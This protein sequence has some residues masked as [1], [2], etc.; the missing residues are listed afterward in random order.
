MLGLIDG[1]IMFYRLYNMN[2]VMQRIDTFWLI[3]CIN[4]QVCYLN[5]NYIGINFEK[6]EFF[7]P[8]LYA[9]FLDYFHPDIKPCFIMGSKLS[10]KEQIQNPIDKTF[11]NCKLITTVSVYNGVLSTIMIITFLFSSYVSETDLKRRMKIPIVFLSSQQLREIATKAMI[12]ARATLASTAD[13]I[14]I[15]KPDHNLW[16]KGNV[17]D[18]PI[19]MQKYLGYR[20]VM[21]KGGDQ[22]CMEK[23]LQK[24]IISGMQDPKLDTFRNLLPAGAPVLDFLSVYMEKSEDWKY[25]PR[26]TIS[27]FQNE[28]GLSY[29]MLN[30]VKV[31]EILIGSTPEKEVDEILL[32]FWAEYFKDQKILPTQVVS[33]DVE[34]IQA[35]LYDVYR[36][37]GRIPCSGEERFAMEWEDQREFEPEDRWTQ[38]PV[39]IMIG[40]G[41]NH[42]L[43]LSLDLNQDS[44]GYY[45][46]NRIKV[47]D[48][49]IK[50]LTMLPVCTGV[51]I[52]HDVRDIEYFFSLVSGVDINMKGFIDLSSLAVLTGYKMQTRNMP[53]MAM[54]VLGMTMNK[55]C[56]TADETWG[57]KWEDVPKALKVYALGDL[58]MG[59]MTYLVLAAVALRDFMPDPDIVCSYF[60]T[61]EQYQV[62]KWFMKLLCASL[63]SAEI[64][65]EDIKIASSRQDL[66]RTLRF[67]YSEDSG[68]REEPTRRIG[69]W[70]KMI[71]GWPSI[72]RGGC[73]YLLQARTQ[74]LDVARVWRQERIVGLSGE[75]NLVPEVS[76]EIK[77]FSVFGIQPQ[78]LDTVDY[79]QPTTDSSGLLRP[80]SLKSKLLMINPEDVKSYVIGKFCAKQPRLQRFIVLE[81][82]R[83][84]LN[85]ITPFLRRM[86]DDVN[87]QKF[88]RHLYDPLRHLFR[89]MLDQEA[90]KVVFMDGLLRDSLRNKREEEFKVY[91]RLL[92][93]GEIRQS[94]IKFL[95]RMIDADDDK[96]RS[97]WVEQ[98]PQLPHWVIQKQRRQARGQKRERSASEDTSEKKKPRKETLQ[99]IDDTEPLREDGHNL[100]ESDTEVVIV[101]EEEIDP[102]EGSSTTYPQVSQDE[103]SSESRLM[104]LF[105]VTN[106]VTK[107][108]APVALELPV[109]VQDE[110]VSPGRLTAQDEI[111]A[112]KPHSRRVI[113]EKR[114]RSKGKKKSSKRF[115]TYDE[116]I[117]AP[118]EM[119]SDNEF[120]L[121]MEFSEFMDP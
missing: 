43:M 80:S 111:S 77:S 84:N 99:S 13:G 70:A 59:H 69:M 52:K 88:Y 42:A 10:L 91:Q 81:W 54:Q 44:K 5:Y 7:Q 93:E 108:L 94:R 107:Q 3:K 38:I 67:R 36:I 51:G 90:L 75:G 79:N 87:F 72:T 71:G 24:V 114:K 31:K 95:D 115:M 97:R 50:F 9:R 39:K 45:L 58:K 89:R 100:S 105:D 29:E 57:R 110:F 101:S 62:I 56:S 86:A 15:P 85:Q 121:E 17:Y 98:I 19:L 14:L 104:G 96:E 25:P 74:F 118:K 83:M 2:I 1:L 78:F 12:D 22:K 32:W 40:N 106:P 82:A 73:R 23:F 116:Q 66:I 8:M 49:V 16:S 35:T 64:H 113:P 28:R 120:T 34:Q 65:T 103:V 92:Q 61:L 119:F 41:L 6:L 48:S 63:D 26:D 11:I 117:E 60:D 18:R 30:Q 46:I 109:R 76:E 55:M 47:Q 20:P 4:G 68:L 37:A 102:M 27:Y 112:Q 53:T 33:L 21:N